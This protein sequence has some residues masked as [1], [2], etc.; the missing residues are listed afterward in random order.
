MEQ[1]LPFW[2]RIRCAWLLLAEK[3][4]QKWRWFF[5]FVVETR[6]S[7]KTMCAMT[8]K[9]NNSRFLVLKMN[10]QNV[11]ADFA[12]FTLVETSRFIG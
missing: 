2:F 9:Q 8:A 4:R 1:L 3:F 5:F 11:A 12:V 7:C 6:L 10:F